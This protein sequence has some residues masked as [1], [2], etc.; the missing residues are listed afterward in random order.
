MSYLTKATLNHKYKYH[1][2]KYLTDLVDIIQL[3]LYTFSYL[4]TSEIIQYLNLYLYSDTQK[5]LQPLFIYE[6][7]KHNKL[8]TLHKRDT[9][10][11]ALCS[12]ILHPKRKLV[13]TV[14][15]IKLKKKTQRCSS[16]S[17]KRHGH[18]FF[19]GVIDDGNIESVL[20]KTHRTQL[21][22]KCQ[23][24]TTLNVTSCNFINNKLIPY[25]THSIKIMY[26]S[27]ISPI[28][29]WNMMYDDLIIE[30]VFKHD[31]QASIDC[32][33]GF[34]HNNIR[35]STARDDQYINNFKYSNGLL[36]LKI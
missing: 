18:D 2:S 19:F 21:S 4:D 10:F 16:I 33:V 1:I 32:V 12:L 13:C 31:H 15:D 25:N 35:M 30:V 29:T 9:H 3:Y 23:D 36:E 17:I 6:K 24:I 20:L 14:I 34:L 28:C 26:N 11:Y 7:N 27:R 8:D 5:K 22:F